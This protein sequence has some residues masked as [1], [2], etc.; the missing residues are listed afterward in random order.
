MSE[1]KTIMEE[2]LEKSEKEKRVKRKRKR[3]MEKVEE[4][5]EDGYQV[6]DLKELLKEDWKEG[7]KL[8]EEYRKK[9]QKL[10]TLQAKYEALDGKSIE[11]LDLDKDFKNPELVDFLEERIEAII[12]LLDKERDV[13]WKAIENQI[14]MK[15]EL[16]EQQVNQQTQMKTQSPA[17]GDVTQETGTEQGSFEEEAMPSSVEEWIKVLKEPD[18]H[19]YVFGRTNF[20]VDTEEKFIGYLIENKELREEFQ[21]FTTYWNLKRDK[22]YYSRKKDLEESST[23]DIKVYDINNPHFVSMLYCL[24]K[25]IEL[26]QIGILNGPYLNYFN[27]YIKNYNGNKTVIRDKKMIGSENKKD[28]IRYYIKERD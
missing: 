28:Y 1:E 8:F 24:S 17:V 15:T 16:I 21:N 26:D 13:K 4:W 25:I 27:D 11:S 5:E 20:N 14:E 22:K 18:D 12:E 7:K 10:K 19:W 3:V 9:I 23:I 2:I 6:E